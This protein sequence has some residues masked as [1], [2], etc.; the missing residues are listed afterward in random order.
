MLRGKA[1]LENI[2]GENNTLKV[3]DFLLMGKDFDFTISHIHNG[4][5]ISRT[6]VR[7]AL[8]Q[9][10]DRDI[11]IVSREDEKSKY[12]KINKSSNKFKLLEGLYE[13]ISQEVMAT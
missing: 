7:N 8:K 11:A 13:E 9:L 1:L 12:Y 6:A 2:F 10:L 3:L 4:V 5:D